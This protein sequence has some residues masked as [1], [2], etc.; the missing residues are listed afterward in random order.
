M[1]FPYPAQP[2]S[3][4]FFTALSASKLYFAVLTICLLLMV[5]FCVTLP[6]YSLI[7][8]IV[9]VPLF[10]PAAMFAP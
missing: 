3:V 10:F 4:H 1:G 5:N 8:V 9:T 6:P 7:P 2:V